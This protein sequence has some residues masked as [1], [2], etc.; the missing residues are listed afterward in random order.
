MILR[1]ATAIL[2]LA[3]LSQ[4]ALAEPFHHPF[5]EWREYNRDWLAACPDAIIEQA[6]SYQ[7]NS[8]YASTYSRQL[9]SA[10]LPAYSLTVIR[11]RLTGEM[12]IAITLADDKAQPDTSRPIIL[13]FAGDK[14]QSMSFSAD[15]ET[16]F[17]TTNQ[18]F[19]VDPQGKAALLK[20]FQERNAVDLRVPLQGPLRSVTTRMSLQGLNASLDF[21]DAF[22][23]RLAQY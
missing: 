11:N 13:L 1:T 3:T 18:Y 19:V 7:G 15:L 8:C 23:R 6:T 2:L 4:G 17:N 12:D 20:S 22:A 10:N 9:N 16:R 5:G 14:P 21:M